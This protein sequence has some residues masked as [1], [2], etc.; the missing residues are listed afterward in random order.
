MNKVKVKIGD[1]VRI[2]NGKDRSKTGL[3]QNVFR[4]EN[5]VVVKGI[6]L[7]KKHVKP[8]KTNPSG[9]IIEVNKKIDISNISLICP[10]CGKNSRVGYKGEK[11]SKIRIC[12][13]CNKSLESISKNG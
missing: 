10:S 13:S 1:N 7:Q 2:V 9:G 12:T 11:K 6:H 3:I 4:D 8:S 5:K